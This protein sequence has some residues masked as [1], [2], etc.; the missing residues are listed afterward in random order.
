[1]SRSRRVVPTSSPRPG[2]P[3]AEVFEA[4]GIPDPG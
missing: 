1:M 4:L 3:E 2:R